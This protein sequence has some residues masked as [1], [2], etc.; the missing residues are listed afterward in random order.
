[1]SLG[2]CL[3]LP[4]WPIYLHSRNQRAGGIQWREGAQKL[5]HSVTAT[6]LTDTFSM[7]IHL[8]VDTQEEM[9]PYGNSQKL[10]KPDK[11]KWMLLITL[12]V[13]FMTSV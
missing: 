6:N 7:Y 10:S 9:F 8:E 4:W 12:F 13:M 2:R 1:M 11:L 3:G 5:Q